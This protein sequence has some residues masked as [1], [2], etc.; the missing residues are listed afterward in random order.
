M[1]YTY[2]QET[3]EECSL[4]SFEELPA[5][6]WSKSK[7]LAEMFCSN[8]CETELSIDAQYGTMFK[9]LTGTRGE[10]SCKKSAADSPAKTYLSQIQTGKG[11]MVLGLGYGMICGELLAKF[12]PITSKWKT[13]GD[14]FPEDLEGCSLNLPKAGMMLDG[15][16]WAATI[17]VPAQTAKGSG[18]TLQRP[19][20]SDGKRFKEY[21]LSSLVRDHHPN[22]N[23]SEQLA[24]RGMK[25]LT[26]ECAE[27]LMRW[28]EG[29]SDLKPLATDKIR[30][31]LQQHTVSC[32]N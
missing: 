30:S 27:I 19:I 24:Q 29:W 6:A 26:P 23:L 8:A 9:P 22:G 18:Y 32:L 7:S 31:W 5:S 20:A 21:K 1:S 11:W 15:Q 14:L 17:Q 3:G 16:L 12:N 25:R 4:E 10:E 13:H 2:L 28:P